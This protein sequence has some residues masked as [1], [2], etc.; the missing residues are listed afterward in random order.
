MKSRVFPRLLYVPAILILFTAILVVWFY[1]ALRAELLYPDWGVTLAA[2]AATGVAIVCSLLL[3]YRTRVL[4]R[5]LGEMVEGV[6]RFEHGELDY[7][8]FVPRDDYLRELGLAL[9]HMAARLDTRFRRLTQRNVEEDAVLS[10]LEE[11]VMAIDLEERILRLNDSARRLIGGQVREPVG[12][13]IQEVVRN[14]QLQRFIRD[15]IAAKAPLESEITLIDVE[16]R[17][18]RVYGRVLADASGG[19]AG[20]IV[21]LSDLTRMR[22][23]E[24]MRRDFVANVSHELRTPITSIKGYVE[25]LLD[26]PVGNPEDTRRF[27]GIISKQADRLDA[28]FEDLLSLARMEHAAGEIVLE[29]G[30]L[31][32]V[33]EQAVASRAGAASEKGLELES[34]VPPDMEGRFNA[35]LLEQAVTN[36]ID[37]AIKF[38]DRGGRVTITATPEGRVLRLSV[39]DTGCGVDAAHLPRLFE[40]FYRVDPSRSRKEGG[41]GLG[42][43]IVKHIA[44]AHGGRA[45]VESAVGKGSTFSIELPIYR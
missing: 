8:L 25:T 1:L 17:H 19:V 3:M 45:V 42:L 13:T 12:R 29:E 5:R 18:L 22:K 37:N 10:T 31:A 26:G 41:T 28:I 7:R 4:Q 11:G 30:N 6:E 38:T 43:A 15:V 24:N 23:L 33:V 34:T 27:L 16:E 21:V 40:R 36:L 20:V 14:I 32:G 9:N 2:G 44:Q 35:T 39:T